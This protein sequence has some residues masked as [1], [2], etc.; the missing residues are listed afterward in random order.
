[1][2]FYFS[3]FHNDFIFQ[4]KNVIICMQN[5]FKFKYIF[6]LD[7]NN[8]EITTDNIKYFFFF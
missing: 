2:I 8:G 6:L 7:N 1:M 3:L 4:K 5:E